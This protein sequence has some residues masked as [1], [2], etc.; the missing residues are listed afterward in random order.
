[1]T[2]RFLLD[3][4]IISEINKKI[5][6][7]LVVDKLNQYQGEV[8]TAS[9]VIHELLFGCLRLP[10]ESGRRHFLEDYIE[11]IPVKMPVLDY[12]IN[13]AKWHAQERA[14]LSKIGKTPAFIDGQ[15][16]SIAFC[17]DLILVTNNVA[18]FQDFEDLII[19]NW[20]IK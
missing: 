9:V 10:P 18:D 13:T 5:P 20:F 15:I 8:V 4:N 1:M 2:F 14:R 6:N 3:T 16:A 12:D 19:E 17:N 7:K 11:E